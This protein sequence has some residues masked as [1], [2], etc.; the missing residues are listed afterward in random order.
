MLKWTKDQILTEIKRLKNLGVAPPDIYKFK[1]SC[2]YVKISEFFPLL[3]EIVIHEKSVA[4]YVKA[5]FDTVTDPRD[6][7]FCEGKC[8]CPYCKS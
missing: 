2:G 8:D 7:N 1:D 5:I 4:E 6:L 3:K